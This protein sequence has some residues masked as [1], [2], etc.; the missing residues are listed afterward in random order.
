MPLFPH[1]YF[2]SSSLLWNQY[3]EKKIWQ[4]K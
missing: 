4:V 2:I 3:K 1:L